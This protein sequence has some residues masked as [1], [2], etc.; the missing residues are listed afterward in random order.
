MDVYIF[1]S[2]AKFWDKDCW[3]GGEGHCVSDAGL[4]CSGAEGRLR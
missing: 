1:S 4:L 3:S 2:V